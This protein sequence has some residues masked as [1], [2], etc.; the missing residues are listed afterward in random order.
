MVYIHLLGEKQVYY[1]CLNNDNCR[2]NFR[3]GSI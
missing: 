3:V 2:Y 1:S